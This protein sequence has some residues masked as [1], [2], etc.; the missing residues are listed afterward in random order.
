LEE[1]VIPFKRSIVAAWTNSVNHLGNT[2]S[3]RAEGQHRVI[4]EYFHSSVGDIL[5][6]VTNIRLSCKNQ[7]REFLSSIAAEKLRKYR[8]F[9]ELFDNVRGHI[10]FAG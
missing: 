10:S 5:N 9:D 4:K 8:G 6:V 7:Y 2:V 3:S 1:N